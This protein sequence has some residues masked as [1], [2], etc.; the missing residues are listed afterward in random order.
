[1]LSEIYK[2]D[3][4]NMKFPSLLIFI[5]QDKI[6]YNELYIPEKDSKKYKLNDII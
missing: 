5:I 6:L 4:N 2:N 1:M 3:L